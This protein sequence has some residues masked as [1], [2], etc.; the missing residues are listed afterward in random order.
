MLQKRWGILTAAATM[1]LCLGAAGRVWAGPPEANA[2][3]IGFRVDSVVASDTNEGVDPQLTSM[4]PRLHALFSYTTYHLVNHQEQQ[5]PIGSLILF[6]LPGGRI[7]HVEPRGMDGDMIVMELTLFQGEQ[8]LMTTELKMRNHGMLMVGGPRYEQGMLIL[9][10]SADCRC[11]RP[12]TADASA[13]VPAQGPAATP[14]SAV[15]E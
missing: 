8:P 11:P 2:P 6:N 5:T 10:I 12:R 14:Q 4:A 13:A 7:L 1:A 15:P 9:S 3:K